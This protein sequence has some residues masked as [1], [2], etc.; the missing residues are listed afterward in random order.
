M[1]TWSIIWRWIWNIAFILINLSPIFF[2]PFCFSWIFWFMVLRKQQDFF[3]AINRHNSPTISD[4]CYIANIP[5][6]KNNYCTCAT[7]FY[8]IF[9]RSTLLMRPFQKHFFSFC[10]SIFNSNLRIF[11]K[12]FISNNQLMKLISKKISACRSTMTIIDCEERAS[13][14]IIYLF[15]L[16]F[17]YIKDNW[18]SVLIII[19]YNTLMSISWIATDNTIL[20]AS[21]FCWVIRSYKSIDLFLFHFYVFLLLLNSHNKSS[22]GCKLI[23]AFRLLN[24]WVS[25]IRWFFNFLMAW[26]WLRSTL[27]FVSSIRWTCVLWFISN[28]WTCSKF[29]YSW[30]GA[31]LWLC[32]WIIQT[33]MMISLCA[34]IACIL[35]WS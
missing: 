22:I 23:L 15:E 31:S 13:G 1:N 3:T 5:N 10:N 21:K 16:W 17:Y 29:I 20:F 18:Y 34:A 25:V 9:M 8:E 32:I 35:V 6:N 27:V 26:R 30:R 11:R 7:S 2:N 33:W 24:I 4:I 19:P 28:S 14:P 12:I